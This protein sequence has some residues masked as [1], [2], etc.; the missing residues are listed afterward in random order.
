MN[1]SIHCNK[2]SFFESLF[3]QQMWFSMTTKYVDCHSQGGCI[4][5][6]CNWIHSTYEEIGDQTCLSGMG[7]G[8]TFDATGL[9]KFMLYTIYWHGSLELCFWPMCLYIIGLEVSSLFCVMDFF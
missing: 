1:D 5:S 9:E 4:L 3:G 6:P 7:Q 2:C 8:N